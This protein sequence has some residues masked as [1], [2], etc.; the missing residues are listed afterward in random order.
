M[1][2]TPPGIL[3]VIAIGYLLFRKQELA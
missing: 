1:K 3:P 2:K